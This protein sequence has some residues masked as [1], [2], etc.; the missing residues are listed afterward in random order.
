[1]SL[2]NIYSIDYKCIHVVSPSNSTLS[3]INDASVIIV[4]A[5][6]D[7]A[8]IHQEVIVQMRSYDLFTAYKHLHQ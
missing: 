7:I 1:M 3:R 2:C 5:E 6:N 4:H 8:S